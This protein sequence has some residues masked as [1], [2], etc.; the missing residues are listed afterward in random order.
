MIVITVARK[1]LQGSVVDNILKH[2]TGGINIDGCRIG[3]GGDVPLFQKGR[4]FNNSP[5]SYGTGRT[6]E[7]ST[8]GRFPSNVILEHKPECRSL[9]FQQTKGNR[10]D[11]R[12]D[13]DG[14][15]DDKTQWRIRPTNATKRGYADENG[16]ET[17]EQWECVEGCP[18][19]HLDLQSG[20][21]NSTA[22]KRGSGGGG[23]HI[24]QLRH[25]P[26]SVRGPTDS[27]G[28]S[29]FFRQIQVEPDC[30]RAGGDCVCEVCGQIFYKHPV[31]GR[32]PFLNVLCDGNRVKL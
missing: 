20:I 11:T 18:V 10:V 28:A 30:N 29:R 31:D 16:M 13:G 3:T 32:F 27:G 7:M 4:H 23:T 9:G 5:T 15:R 17:V 25:R 2:G 6:G 24:G 26:N 19:H 8:K 12:P 21:S 22:H 1:P 14:G